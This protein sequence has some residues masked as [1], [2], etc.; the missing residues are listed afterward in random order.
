MQAFRTVF[1]QV[2]ADMRHVTVPKKIAGVFFFFFTSFS[3]FQFD[4]KGYSLLWTFES[5]MEV[6]V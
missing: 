3:L 6:S 2:S 5:E 4:I 1:R